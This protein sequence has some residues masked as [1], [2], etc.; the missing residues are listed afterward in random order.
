MFV[1]CRSKI[2][3]GSFDKTAKIWDAETGEKLHNLVGHKKEIVCVSFDCHSIL[4]ATGSM[5]NTAKLWD[6]ETG[7]EIYSLEGHKGEIVAL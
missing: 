5:D 1:F 2:V 6:V 7:K 3:T 4:V